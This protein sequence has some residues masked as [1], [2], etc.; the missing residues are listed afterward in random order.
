MKIAFDKSRGK[1]LSKKWR[2]TQFKQN[3]V[4]KKEFSF[5]FWKWNNFEMNLFDMKSV[6]EIIMENITNNNRDPISRST[7]TKK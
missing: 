6:G 4:P 2:K 1:N 3:F 7:T 5:I